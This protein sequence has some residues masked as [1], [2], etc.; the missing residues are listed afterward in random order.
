M[1]FKITL[2]LSN[3]GFIM[4]CHLFKEGPFHQGKVASKNAEFVKMMEEADNSSSALP[5]PDKSTSLKLN[6][7]QKYQIII[8][9]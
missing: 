7:D 4:E 5:H 8:C 1:V 3:P 6:G 2:V 9:S